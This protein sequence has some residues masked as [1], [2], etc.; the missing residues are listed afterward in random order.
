MIFARS[1]PMKPP[2]TPANRRFLL[3]RNLPALLFFISLIIALISG[4][5]LFNPAV[6]GGLS[7]TII[8]VGLDPSRAQLIAVLIM[9]AATALA[10]AVIG[11]SKLGALLG[12]WIVFLFGYL[13]GFIQLETQPTYDPGGHLEPL[14]IGA[15]VHTSILMI[16]LALLC[17]FIGA[18]VGV[19]LSEVLLDP[20]YRLVR[21]LWYRYSHTQE[22][23]EQIYI[24]TTRQ[25]AVFTI[26]GSWFAAVA[27]IV[28]LVLASSS[29]ELFTYYPEIGLHT[30]PNIAKPTIPAGGETIPS[31]GTVVQDSLISPILG[32]QRRT[33]LVYLPP[34]YNTRIGQTKRYPALYLLHGSPGQ[35]HDWFTAGKANQS[36]DTLIA[37]G[38][39]PE[40]ILV[41]PD[42]NGRAG[43]TSEWGNS[44]DQ[45]Q[46]IESYVVNDVVKYVDSKYRTIPD[47]AHRAI[48]GLSMGGFG[49]TNIAVH[50]PDVFGSVIS[51]GGYYHAEGSTWGNNAAYMR[52][53]SPADVLPTN[54][55][56]WKLLFFLGAGKQDQPY[57]TYTQQFAQELDRLH[58][59][60]QLDVQQG[61]HSWI[62]WQ[63]QMYNALVWLHWGQ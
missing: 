29:T 23:T 58:I 54:K 6:I 13:F 20:L 50:H 26:I 53:N 12:A 33:I 25:G 40:L 41:L 17:A 22:D 31:H 60:Y 21:S 24:S 51:L 5:L 49:A 45:R 44:Y 62:I 42:G 18:A 3:R 57:Y 2:P 43:A 63:I 34:T 47:V 7:S 59:P 15:L 32:G 52:L 11:R 56:A 61:Y 10:G 39:I 37:L 28:L 46:L 27:M 1:L 48:G 16:A 35:A 14:V 38:K 30:V 8:N 19:A 55:Q 4:I 36:A 9:T